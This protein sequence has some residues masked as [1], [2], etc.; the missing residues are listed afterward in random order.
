MAHKSYLKGVLFCLIAT[1]SWGAMFPIMTGALAKIDPFTFTALRYT[2][3]G[4][5]FLLLLLKKEGV[6]ALQLKGERVFLAWFLGTL[7][8]AG[9]GFLVFM[10][11]QMAGATG[12]LTASIMMATMPMLGLLVNWAIRRMRPPI[13][14]FLFILMSFS[15]VVLVITKGHIL[16]ILSEPQHY[17][18]DVPIILG[19]L[20]WVLYTVGGSF[21]PKWSPYRYTTITTLLGLSSVYAVNTVLI[22]TGVVVIPSMA[23]VVSISPQLIYMALIAGFVGVLSWNMGNKIITPMNGV[24]FMDV[25]PITAFTISALTGVVAEDA[26]IVGATITATALILNN[27]YQ[28]RRMARAAAPA[29]VTVPDLVPGRAN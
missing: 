12:A 22:T 8:F 4:A 3:A 1:I 16:G 13:Y 19:A 11:Q 15:G 20:C 2:I 27:L 28:R 25:V 18:A 7:G 5:V 26:Q 21:Y 17:A 24:L 29:P 14:S 23:T 10:G 9:F 6:A